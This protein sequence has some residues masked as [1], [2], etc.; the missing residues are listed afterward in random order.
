[1]CMQV[2]SEFRDFCI[3]VS[4]SELCE[5]KTVSLFLLSRCWIPFK[6]FLISLRRHPTSGSHVRSSTVSPLIAF[7]TPQHFGLPDFD[8]NSSYMIDFI[9]SLLRYAGHSQMVRSKLRQVTQRGDDGSR[10]S[11]SI[12]G[13]SHPHSIVYFI[14]RG[15]IR[16]FL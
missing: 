14:S 13:L 4:D 8:Y 7:L 3:V 1:M 16:L 15:I 10:F 5:F 9:P 12:L 2:S 6:G 11:V